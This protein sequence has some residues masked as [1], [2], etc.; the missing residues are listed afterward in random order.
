MYNEKIFKEIRL[1]NSEWNDYRVNITMVTKL[2]IVGLIKSVI[3]NT[4]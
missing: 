1:N 2:V 4:T 3:L